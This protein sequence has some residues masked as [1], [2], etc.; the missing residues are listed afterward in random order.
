MEVK[1]VGGY[2]KFENP[3]CKG[4]MIAAFWKNGVE[5]NADFLSSSPVIRVLGHSRVHSSC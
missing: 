3:S 2:K 4:E 1:V 5:F